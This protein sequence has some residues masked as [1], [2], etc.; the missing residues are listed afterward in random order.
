MSNFNNV[1]SGIAASDLSGKENF[2]LK[3]TATGW[4]IAGASDRVLG[5][6]ERG[7]VAGAAVAIYLNKQGPRFIQIGNAT[8]IAIGDE[9]EQAAGGYLVKK[10]TGAAVAVAIEAAPASSNNGG[11]IRAILL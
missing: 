10:N 7:A 6:C 5:T 2:A 11:Q 9:L 4:D 3:L 1:I 8:A